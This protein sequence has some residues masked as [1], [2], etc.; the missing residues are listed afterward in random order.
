MVKYTATATTKWQT[1]VGR[2]EVGSPGWQ[3]SLLIS[4]KKYISLFGLYLFGHFKL[5]I[6]IIIL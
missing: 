2:I 4:N 5:I 1:T 3:T 6:I